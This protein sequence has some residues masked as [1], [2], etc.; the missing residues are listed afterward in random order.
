[1]INSLLIGV[2]GMVGLMVLWYVVQT[3]W[4]KTFADHLTDEDVMAGRSTCGSC[5]CG[6]SCKL[7][8]VE[9]RK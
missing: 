6:T 9:S 3:L 1:M 8:K 4:G 7:K 2:G 5:G